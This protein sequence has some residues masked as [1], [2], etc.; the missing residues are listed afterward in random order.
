MVVTEGRC[1]ECGRSLKSRF[2]RQNSYMWSVV[3]QAI[4][5]YTGHSTEEVHEF[6][7]QMFLPRKFVQIGKREREVTKS[8]T[9]L[10]TVEMEEYLMRVRVFANQELGIIVP[11]PNEH[12][13]PIP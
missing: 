11:L 10:G 2:T 8:T 7:K 6:C 9:D 4:A 1:K 3:Y 5:D 12:G 13:L